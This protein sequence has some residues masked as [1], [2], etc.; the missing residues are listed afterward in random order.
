M[1]IFYIPLSSKSLQIGHQVFKG[2]ENF[3]DNF[4]RHTPISCILSATALQLPET[5]VFNHVFLPLQNILEKLSAT[6]KPAT[7]KDC[8]AV[9]DK[10]PKNATVDEY[11]LE[12]LAAIMEY[13]GGLTRKQVE[14]A[15]CG[16]SAFINL[17]GVAV[18]LDRKYYIRYTVAKCRT[19]QSM[20][21][22][23]QRIQSL[24]AQGE[25]STIEFKTST[26]QL[27]RAFETICGFLNGNGGS[28]LLGVSDSGAIVG[29][30]ISDKT[31]QVQ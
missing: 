31:K 25:S 19:N 23:I 26:S 13:D 24:I 4:S 12:E 15:V 3:S 6:R 18:L 20:K 9:A 8:S 7:S 5:D 22:D 27:Q 17:I 16:R 10:M 14:F 11:L 2:Y 21:M 28:V 29:Q 1:I 30:E